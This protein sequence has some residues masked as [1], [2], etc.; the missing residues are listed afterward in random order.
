MKMLKE[1]SVDRGAYWRCADCEYTSK[2][3]RGMFEHIE[4]K[5]V[6]SE[7]YSCQ[8]CQKHC[9]T[10]NAMRSHMSRYHKQQ[11]F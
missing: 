11:V 7:G 5:H 1:T 2:D 6:G 3:K 9:P 10:K 8:I 4:S